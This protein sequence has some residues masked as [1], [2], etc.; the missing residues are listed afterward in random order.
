MKKLF[1]GAILPFLMFTSG[2]LLLGCEPTPDT[3][4]SLQE[5]SQI[6]SPQSTEQPIQHDT[7]THPTTDRVQDLKSGNMLYIVRDVADVQMK[8][9]DYVEKLKQTQ[10][11]L[12]QAL[13]AHNQSELQSTV[14]NLSSQLRNFNTALISLDLKSQEIDG[15]RQQVLQA[16][17]QILNSSLLNGDIDISQVDFKKIEQQLNHIQTDMLQ[18]ATMMIPT[19]G[20]DQRDS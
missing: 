9:G 14:Q 8:T 16:N 19:S 13:D 15:I 11:D 1:Q 10:A 20:K 6:E 3:H 12:Q 5:Q 4:A 2:V 7:D 18:L 17:K